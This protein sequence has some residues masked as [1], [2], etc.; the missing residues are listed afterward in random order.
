M[1]ETLNAR[2]CDFCSDGFGVKL[3][4]EG[5]YLCDQCR[6]VLGPYEVVGE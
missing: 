6:E 3:V 2:A 5:F 1:T 4:E